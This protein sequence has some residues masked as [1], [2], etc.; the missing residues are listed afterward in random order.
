ME[1]QQFDDGRESEKPRDPIYLTAAELAEPYDVVR[2]K[3]GL[4]D[5]YVRALESGD[6]AEAPLA[7]FDSQDTVARDAFWKGVEDPSFK[8]RGHADQS[9]EGISKRTYLFETPEYGDVGITFF[10]E[11]R[12][13][14]VSVK[15][16]PK[17]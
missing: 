5:R 7:M 9:K 8:P 13:T 3:A 17:R 14:K 6:E 4:R 10:E 11:D 15:K 1:K 12:F 2:I 16:I